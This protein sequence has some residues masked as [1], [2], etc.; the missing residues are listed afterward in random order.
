MPPL[1]GR[2][3]SLTLD[4]LPWVLDVA[5]QRRERIAS[6][7]P[8]FW[9]PAPD[10]RDRHRQFFGHQI[11]DP[12][13][14]TLRTDHGFVFAA[15]RGQVLDVDDLALDDD[16]LWAHDGTALLQAALQDGDLR[17]VC[18]VPEPARTQTAVDL[19]MILVESW[20]HRDLATGE[21]AITTVESCIAPTITVDG[22][23]GR[24]VEA[25]PVYDS[26]GPVL[27]VFAVDSA[28]ALT[29][30]EATGA[31]A[32]AKVSVVSR[33]PGQPSDMLN[34]SGYKRTTDFF[35]WYR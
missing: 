29:A 2:V 26:G 4:D 12:H 3:R 27:L 7:A 28:A 21:M 5:G 6:F 15:P 19:G 14:L 23:S 13:V 1:S 34:S 30:I 10:A 17:F 24:L 11:R 32:G 16:D 9:H 18:P 25:P 20:W 35:T 31:A 22:A 33:S 8:R